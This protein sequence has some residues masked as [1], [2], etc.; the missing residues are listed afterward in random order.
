MS[1]TSLLLSTKFL[2]MT[3]I[4]HAPSAYPL[5]IVTVTKILTNWMACREM[6]M[7]RTKLQFIP[8]LQATQLV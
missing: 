2:W 8:P 1:T 3:T 6:L 5:S 7:N 4:D